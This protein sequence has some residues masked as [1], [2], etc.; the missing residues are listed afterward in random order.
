MMGVII[1]GFDGTSKLKSQTVRYVYLTVYCFTG[2][3]FII[4]LFDVCMG[5]YTHAYIFLDLQIAYL[6][7]V[8]YNIADWTRRM[9][10]YNSLELHGFTR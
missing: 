7:R 9:L 6:F 3:F 1:N 10:S 8:N 2:S 5:I 4:K